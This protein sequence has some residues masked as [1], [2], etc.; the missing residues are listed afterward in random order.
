MNEEKKTNILYE[1]LDIYVKHELTYKEVLEVLEQAK[2]AIDNFCLNQK[3]RPRENSM[4]DE[5]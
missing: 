3:F 1:F 4:P 2:E 5:K